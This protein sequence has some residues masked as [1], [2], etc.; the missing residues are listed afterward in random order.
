MGVCLQVVGVVVFKDDQVLLV[1]HLDGASH[2][3]G[4]YGLPAGRIEPGE[5][6]IDAA[7]RELEEE[8]GL[9]ALPENLVELPNV[10]SATIERKTG[11]AKFEMTSYLCTGYAG[12][13]TD[14]DETSPLFVKIS[15][16]DSY[17][18]IGTGHQV[19]K[20]ALEMKESLER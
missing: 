4:S 6:K 20:D 1:K 15:E 7:K 12:T 13:L 3:T 10:Y 2:L 14:S 8:S 11:I 17:D 19:I 9:V 18:L 16:L 5:S